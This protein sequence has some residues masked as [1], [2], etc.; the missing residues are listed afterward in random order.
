MI[1]AGAKFG[2]VFPLLD[3]GER[4]GPELRARFVRRPG[5]VSGKL[6]AMVKARPA[7]RPAPSGMVPEAVRVAKAKGYEGDPCPTCG[8]LL[9]RRAGA[10]CVCDGCK[11]SSGCG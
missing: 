6:A 2:D 7:G 1:D 11:E 5:P 8:A 4:D 9:L 3:D 10:C